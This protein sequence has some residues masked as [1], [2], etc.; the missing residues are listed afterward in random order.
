MVHYDKIKYVTP[1]EAY[2]HMTNGAQQQPVTPADVE[3]AMFGAEA[4][5]KEMLARHGIANNATSASAAREKMIERQR[6]KK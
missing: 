4:A 2:R 6:G 1:E 5:R 3:K